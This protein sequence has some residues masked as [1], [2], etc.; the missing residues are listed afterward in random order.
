M[1]AVASLA[2]RRSRVPRFEFFSMDG[3][4][5][6]VIHWRIRRTHIV[7]TEMAAFTVYTADFQTLVRNGSD[8]RVAILAFQI[9]VN[10]APECF[11]V[12]EH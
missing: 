12:Y 7:S 9:A 3:F 11:F 5:K 4:P 6:L 10:R 1:G 8:I 2:L